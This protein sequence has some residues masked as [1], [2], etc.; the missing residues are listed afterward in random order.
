MQRQRRQ[1][2]PFHSHTHVSPR[3]SLHVIDF[4]AASLSVFHFIVKSER[5]ELDVRITCIE[6]GAMRFCL[7]PADILEK[8]WIEDFVGWPREKSFPEASSNAT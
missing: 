5:T 1:A 2:F 4:A 3:R 8:R 7:P 6:R